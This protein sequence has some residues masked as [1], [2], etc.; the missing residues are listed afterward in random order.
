MPPITKDQETSTIAPDAA[1]RG[2]AVPVSPGDAVKQQPVALEVSVTV[3]GARTIEG[4]DKREPFSE[5]TK[6]VLIFGNGAVI[7]L[8]SSVAPGQLLFLTN[9]RTKK[10]VVCQV[11]KSKN[12]R[13][14][15]GYV[16][17][18][19][20]EPVVGFWGMRFP[21]DRLGATPAPAPVAMPPAISVPPAPPRPVAPR[22]EEPT[23]SSAPSVVLPQPPPTPAPIAPSVPANAIPGSTPSSSPRSSI[24]P[25]PIDSGALLGASKPRPAEIPAPVAPIPA[26][27]VAVAPPQ[28]APPQPI[29]APAPLAADPA[30]APP[31]AP[32]APVFEIASRSDEPASFLAP[33]PQAPKA[34]A[35]IDL[36]NLAPFFEVKP[37]APVVAAPPPPPP[38][39]VTNP[40]T[41]A[42]KQQ[43]ARLQEQLS[44]MLFTETAISA[45]AVAEPSAETPAEPVTEKK[46]LQESIAQVLEIAKAP[47]AKPEPVFAL[48]PEPVKTVSDNKLSS[49]EEEEL[50]IPA[51]LEPLA[52]NS[53]A[54]SST[55]ELI[56]REK[57]KRLS[58]Q[59]NREKVEVAD[60][61][62]PGTEP[63]DL[64]QT[65]PSSPEPRMPEFGSS[66]VI[67][68]EIHPTET[69][70]KRS[71]KGL[72]FAAIAAGVVLLTAGGWWYL[73]QR[74]TAAQA[75]NSQAQLPAATSTVASVAAKPRV[76]TAPAVTPSS[77]AENPASPASSAQSNTLSEKA[78]AV[79]PANEIS[80]VTPND[81]P[82]NA[83][84]SSSSSNVPRMLT[85]A[86]AA[87]PEAVPAQVK[88]PVLGDVHL[89]TPKVSQNRTAQNEITA[90]EGVSLND[91][92][93]ENA[94]DSLGSGL[95]VDTKQPSAP[96]MP[97][98]VGGDVKQAKLISTVAPLYP[99]LAKS[100]HIQ[101]AV[102]IDALIDATG[103]VSSMKII[104][105]PTL[106]HQAAM[107][108]LKQW[109]YQPATLDGKPVPMHL[110]V[111]V[112]FRLQQ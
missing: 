3:N 76:E 102:A 29:S 99:A 32:P 49:L 36:S 44:S 63:A 93:P 106:L 21:G 39:A 57:A 24:V 68:E 91:D 96:A 97:V 35:T 80:V 23:L 26:S 50:K 38:P 41:E 94:A 108:A 5:S 22:I 62:A 54:P 78:A 89:A 30:P 42:L 45:P 71:G 55:Q 20:T 92:Q 51:W 48:P 79:T 13:N 28:P 104:S 72:L 53:S 16:E 58:E 6:T 19:F 101:G 75:V 10:E 43:T 12:Y 2:G 83:K 25:P 18:E 7:R 74:P 37:A 84:A 77:V 110:T 73:N 105:G 47:A 109:K 17:L 112:Q 4:S 60:E 9:E 66:L 67:D 88:K 86:S 87:Q 40:E 98:P 11:V 64:Q 1:T 14:V 81:S 107:D 46:E 34:P 27:P 95:T 82:R 52:R 31:I 59:P 90:D 33:G 65:E 61:V 15:S 69:A 70:G 100:Q 56:L 111:T 8:T 103:R 85:T